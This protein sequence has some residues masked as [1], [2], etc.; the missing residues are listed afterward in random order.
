MGTGPSTSRRRTRSIM[1]STSFWGTAAV[2]SP[3]SQPS[4]TVA[5]PPTFSPA[6]STA[7]VADILVQ[8]IFGTDATVYLGNGDGTFQPGTRYTGP[9][10]LTSL[11]LR[12]MNGDGRPDMVIGGFNNTIDILQ[13]NADG[14][15]STVSSGGTANGGPGASLLAV[16]DFN[17]DGIL[18]IA[19]A[20]SNGISILLGQRNLSYTPPIPYSGIPTPGG[21]A[22]ADLNGDGFQ[23]FAE[24]APGGVAL[25]FGAA[26]GTLQGADLYDLGEGLNGI[27]V[28]DFTGDHLPDIAVNVAEPTPR[29]LIGKGGGQFSVAPS[30]GQTSSTA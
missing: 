3:S 8:G 25:L 22:T 2:R 19:A 11:L 26:G 7:T 17:S 13:G 4:S 28:A 10:N 18:D 27:A 5:V 9:H 30:T 1:P 15:F 21:P 14:T 12:D 24:L 6:I 23:D 16:F 29:L 20:G